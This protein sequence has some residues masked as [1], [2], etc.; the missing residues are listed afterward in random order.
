MQCSGW[1]P[2]TLIYVVLAIASTIISLFVT[3]HYDNLKNQGANKVLYAIIH[4]V[5][6]SFW[7]WVLYWLCSN[8]HSN[9]AWFVL[10]FPNILFVIYIVIFLSYYYTKKVKLQNLQNGYQIH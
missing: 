5:V 2:P 8:C 4:L 10:L 6:V 9:A 1:C 3:N 7:T